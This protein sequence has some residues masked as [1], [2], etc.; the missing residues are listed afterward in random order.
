[1][2]NPRL[3]ELETAKVILAGIFQVRATDVEEMI[4]SRMEE[5]SWAV[6]QTHLSKDGL[7]LA[8]LYVEV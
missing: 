4:Q 3:A 1:M 5:R 2:I 6:E 8:T 7:W